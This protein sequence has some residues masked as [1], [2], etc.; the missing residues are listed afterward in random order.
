MKRIAAMSAL[1]VMTLAGV[2]VGGAQTTALDRALDEWAL[3]KQV[4]IAPSVRSDLAARA[5]KAVDDVHKN[6][7]NISIS[8]LRELVPKAV[9]SYLEKTQSNGTSPPLSDL[10][11]DLAVPK[12]LE[13]AGAW[14]SINVYPILTVE[15]TPDKPADFVVAIDGGPYQAGLKVFRVLAGD[16]SVRVT[17]SNRPPCVAVVKVTPIGPNVVA[18]AM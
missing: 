10:L 16:R 2:A 13:E 11:E 7:P 8:R 17:R 1:V 12:V 3:A 18:C 14:G 6:N 5:Q 4:G 15:I 9:V